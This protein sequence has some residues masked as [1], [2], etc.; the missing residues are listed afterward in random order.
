MYQC[1]SLPYIL[2]LT[3]RLGYRRAQGHT[4]APTPPGVFHWPPDDPG[5]VVLHLEID[6]DVDAVFEDLFGRK[7][8]LQ[9]GAWRKSRLWY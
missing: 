1:L 7:S 5:K 3:L 2:S 9:V 6:G 4:M 8:P